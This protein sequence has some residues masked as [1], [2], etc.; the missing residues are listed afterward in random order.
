MKFG[1]FTNHC[2]CW[3]TKGMHGWAV[4]CLGFS[5]EFCAGNPLVSKVLHN[6]MPAPRAGSG[7]LGNALASRWHLVWEHLCSEG[8]T[9]HRTSAENY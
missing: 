8:I 4:C 2:G 9:R 3:F 1:V 7:L 6:V 5:P